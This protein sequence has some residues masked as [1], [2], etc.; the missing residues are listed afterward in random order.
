MSD[1]ALTDCCFHQWITMH[2]PINVTAFICFKTAQGRSADMQH[3]AHHSEEGCQLWQTR[4]GREKRWTAGTKKLWIGR[5]TTRL[6]SCKRASA[7]PFMLYPWRYPKA[8]FS[9]HHASAL[10]LKYQQVPESSITPEPAFCAPTAAPRIIFPLWIVHVSI[11]NWLLQYWNE[12]NR[13]LISIIAIFKKPS[14]YTVLYSQNKA[15]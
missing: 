12:S 7:A 5:Q 13:K 15:P 2:F 4:M 11:W 9:K 14:I 6:Q 8:P 3:L 10:R 1:F